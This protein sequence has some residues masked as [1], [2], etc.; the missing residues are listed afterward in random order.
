MSGLM[1]L[2]K[3]SDS[4]WDI[5][6]FTTIGDTGDHMASLFVFLYEVPLKVKSVGLK[7]GLR[8]FM[9]HLDI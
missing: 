5:N 8:D 6:E 9:I 4:M 3:I 2:E 1:M 7:H